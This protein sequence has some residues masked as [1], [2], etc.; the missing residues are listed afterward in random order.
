MTLVTR[1]AGNVG[2][3]DL[4]QPARCDHP[5]AALDVTDVGTRTTTT[6]F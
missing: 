6:S 3:E 1:A 2:G 5:G 4:R